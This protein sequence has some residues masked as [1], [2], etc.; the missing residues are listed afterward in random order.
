MRACPP[1]ES[2]TAASRVFPS[3]KSTASNFA[4]FRSGEGLGTKVQIGGIEFAG[5][6][7]ALPVEGR[8]ETRFHGDQAFAAKR[9]DDAI[10]VH[11]RKT[12]GVTDG[13]LRD[14]QLHGEICH[15]SDY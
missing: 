8:H 3:L 5:D 7:Q 9:L 4:E 15:L 14:R 6:F 11:G 2:K 1:R 12:E 10:D 13:V